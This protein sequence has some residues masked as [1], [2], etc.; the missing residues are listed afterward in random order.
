M[1][2]IRG[3]QGLRGIAA[4]AVVWS[5]AYA[6]AERTWIAEIGRSYLDP[7]P[8]VIQIG[9]FGVDLFFVLS[10]FLMTYLHQRDFGQHDA[11]RE[12]LRRRITR[13]VPLY[14]LLSAAGLLLLSL[15]PALFSY[16][17]GI[18]W[19]WMLGC[20][21]FIPWPMS[22]GFS[23]PIIGTGWTLD[24][25]MYFYALFALALLF[26][27]GFRILCALMS[28]S[29][30]L[31]F[32]L[33][34]QHPWPQ[35]LTSP[36]LLEFMLG[37][38]IA[39]YAQR[40]SR[41]AAIMLMAVSVV[42]IAV[43]GAPYARSANQELTRVWCWGIPSALLLVATVRLAP[44]CNGWIGRYLV[45]LGDASY[46]IYLFQ[47]F[48]LPTIAIALRSLRI[49][50]LLPIDLAITVLWM[51]TCL[52]GVVCWSCIEKPMTLFFKRK[53]RLRLMHFH[54]ARR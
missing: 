11:P 42:L 35:L 37:A 6:R 46:S 29:I 32:T 20:F 51:L 21:A 18:E 15:G 2:Q 25:E 47:V 34:P 16:H 24:Y 36:M 5:H 10:G 49:P 23:S 26:R 19:G 52:M 54:V 28:M 43:G 39:L 50:V 9:H 8:A 41:R 44:S 1:E 30:I 7:H 31:G 33:K 4:C 12:F 45:R 14:W 48:A 27:G 17:K 38:F 13:V 22:D 53:H 3:L 40:F